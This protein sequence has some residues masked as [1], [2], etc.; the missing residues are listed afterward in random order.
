MSS[1]TD[2]KQR[3]AAYWR[4]NLRLVGGLLAVWFVASFG[5]GILFVE[6]L[7]SIKMG[8]FP[9]GFWVAQQGSILVFVVLVIVYAL[10]MDRLENDQEEL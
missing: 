2:K 6:P 9:L 5:L 7:N 8:G 10:R 1:K 3:Q 4:Q